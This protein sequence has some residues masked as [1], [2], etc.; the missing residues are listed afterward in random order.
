MP[1]PLDVLTHEVLQLSAKD[2]ALLF[3]R[4]I[5]SLEQDAE[6]DGR[7]AAVAAER[8]AAADADAD[9]CVAGSE[10]LARVRAQVT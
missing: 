4:L 2:R 1:L 9:L 3:N 10:A 8:D 6:R 5:N 7:W